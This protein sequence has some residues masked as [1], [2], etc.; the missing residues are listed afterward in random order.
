M[1]G[2]SFVVGTT[3]VIYTMTDIHGNESSSSFF[4]TVTDDQVP[5]IDGLPSNITLSAEAG[6]C[7]ATVGWTAPASSDNCDI[8]DLTSTHLPGDSFAVGTTQVTYT[9]TDIHGNSTSE[10][11]TV[12][13]EDLESP[14]VLDTPADMTLGNDAGACGAVA[15]WAPASASDNCGVQ[16][17]TSSHASGDFFDVGST[18][19]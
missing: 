9:T 3:E 11:F 15:T 7:S 19:W 6:L 1:P 4:V 12:T 18:R 10:S 14:V 13:V 8:A 17:L 5:S 16:S 2:D